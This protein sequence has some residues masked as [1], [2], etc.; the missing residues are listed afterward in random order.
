MRLSQRDKWSIA[1]VLGLAATAIGLVF[2]V[3]LLLPDQAAGRWLPPVPPTP[4]PAPS[5]SVGRIVFAFYDANQQQSDIG[6]IFADGSGRTNLT[7]TPQQ[8]EGS[9]AWS[10]D[11]TQIAFTVYHQSQQSIRESIMLMQADGSQVRTLRAFPDTVCDLT[12][13]PN[14][15]QLAFM[16]PCDSAGYV[17]RMSSDGT[18]LTEIGR[19]W[20]PRWSPDGSWFLIQRSEG[21][22][23]YTKTTFYLLRAD[24]AAFVPLIEA[25][26]ASWAPR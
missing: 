12:W 16:S 5:R 9:P 19:G 24:G 22:M 8:S 17:Y 3:V 11:A 14:G 18:Q 10:P 7:R 15:T 6:L 21:G 25:S 2:G 23:E 20:N 13:S 26:Q 4:T 1:L